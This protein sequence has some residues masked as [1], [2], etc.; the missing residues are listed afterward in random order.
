M[1]LRTLVR[2]H[3]RATPSSSP[4]H[5][6]TS[7]PMHARKKPCIRVH[8]FGSLL[9]CTEQMTV[10]GSDR[11]V[12]TKP[13]L[14]LKKQAL[15]LDLRLNR[16]ANPMVFLLKLMKINAHRVKARNVVTDFVTEARHA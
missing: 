8:A 12:F 14:G 2:M 4:V 5:A 6:F 10:Q 3:A 1:N 7:H 15:R 13:V 16:I 11:P 9:H